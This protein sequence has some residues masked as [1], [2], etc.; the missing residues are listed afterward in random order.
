MKLKFQTGVRILSASLGRFQGPLELTSAHEHILPALREL[1]GNVLLKVRASPGASQEGV[2]GLHGEALK[3]A[4]A[5]PPEKGKAN[6]AIAR[7]LARHL[8]LRPSQVK[9]HSGETSRDKWFRL[10]GVTLEALSKK[11]MR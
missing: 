2:K 9:V 3:V 10:E 7:V 1:D 8:S 6:E 4:V 5:A 11:L